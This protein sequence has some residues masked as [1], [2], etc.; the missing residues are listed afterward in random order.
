M[1]NIKLI[2]I[3]P[4]DKN[5]ST[6]EHFTLMFLKNNLVHY[7]INSIIYMI[8]HQKIKFFIFFVEKL[9]NN[10]LGI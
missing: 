7:H 4:F 3:L 10:L 2:N 1:F 5:C 6:H 9:Q 8:M